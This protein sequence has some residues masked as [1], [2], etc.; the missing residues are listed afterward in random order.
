MC[1][2]CVFR[3]TLNES[4][5]AVGG[6]SPERRHWGGTDK[7][8]GTSGWEAMRGGERA[9]L[10]KSRHGQENVNTTSRV[11]AR[12]LCRRFREMTVIR[13]VSP[14]GA[15]LRPLQPVPLQW[16]H[17]PPKGNIPHTNF[18]FLLES[19]VLFACVQSHQCVC[20][21]NP[22]HWQFGSRSISSQ[23]WRPASVQTNTCAE[24]VWGGVGRQNKRH[25]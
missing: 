25:R 19:L 6:P 17:I 13:D 14:T 20:I 15:E 5:A 10:E 8:T 21:S 22:P 4:V 9:P 11:L 2:F 18:R 3:G 16:P 24:H 7:E 12:R 23:A 1:G